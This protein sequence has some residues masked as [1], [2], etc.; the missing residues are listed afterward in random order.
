MAQIPIAANRVGHVVQMKTAKAVNA[1]ASPVAPEKSAVTMAVGVPVVLV[2]VVSLAPTV[3]AANP[4]VQVLSVGT[5][6]VV[7]PAVLAT[8]GKS[9]NT[10]TV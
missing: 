8:A 2:T 9:V 10:D 6:V 3:S 4:T 5:T 1:S 7:V